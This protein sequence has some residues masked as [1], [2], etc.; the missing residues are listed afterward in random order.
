MKKIIALL[1]C[2]IFVFSLSACNSK[3]KDENSNNVDIE[4]YANS[5]SMPETNYSLGTDPEKIKDELS[6]LAA[7]S[8]EDFIF[9]VVEGEI[10]SL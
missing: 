1:L 2:V 9:D 6:A 3:E 10:T 4:Y 8:E 5:G 7:N